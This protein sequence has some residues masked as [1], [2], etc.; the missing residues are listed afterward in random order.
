MFSAY[1]MAC[2][3]CSEIL[4]ERKGEAREVDMSRCGEG[5]EESA[6]IAE[7]YGLTVLPKGPLV[8][9]KGKV[10]MGLWDRRVCSAV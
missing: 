1:C 7:R 9:K 3:R 2:H 5:R 4:G 6:F 10:L 8:N